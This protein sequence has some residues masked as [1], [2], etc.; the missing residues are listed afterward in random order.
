[1]KEM[2]DKFMMRKLCDK[3]L[4]IS[5]ISRQNDYNRKALRKFIKGSDLKKYKG[6]KNQ[7][8]QFL[9]NQFIILNLDL[10]I[11]THLKGKGGVL[12]NICRNIDHNPT[13][14]M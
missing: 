12:M 5:E 6:K 7:L 9:Y 3:G 13:F 2:E 8:I 4:S 11:F 1:M 14:C 10:D